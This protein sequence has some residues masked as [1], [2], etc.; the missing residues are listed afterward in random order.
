LD[1]TIFPGLFQF[2]TNFQAILRLN[3]LILFINT[4]PPPAI[5]KQAPK[6]PWLYFYLF[7]LS[8]W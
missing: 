5:S 8:F 7:K 6:W 3:H 1:T 2:P 4:A